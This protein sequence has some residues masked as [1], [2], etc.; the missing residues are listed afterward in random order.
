[1][2]MIAPV[3]IPTATITAVTDP[4]YTPHRAHGA[5]NPCAYGAADNAANRA[6]D[7]VALIGSFLGPPHDA[8]SMPGMGY[9]DQRKR[10]GGSS[11]RQADREARGHRSRLNFGLI[12]LSSLKDGCIVAVEAGPCNASVTEKLRTL[13]SLSRKAETAC[14][15]IGAMN[16]IRPPLGHFCALRR[17]NDGVAGLWNQS[18]IP[19]IFNAGGRERRL[20]QRWPGGQR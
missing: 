10:D 20:L 19:G 11:E 2:K 1:M 7:P 12:H 16:R 17:I 8:L 13:A 9:R 6:G 3:I 15:E 18:W 14:E 4:E 5:T